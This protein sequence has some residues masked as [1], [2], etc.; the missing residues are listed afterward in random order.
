MKRGWAHSVGRR[1]AFTLMEAIAAIVVLGVIV[2]PSVSMLRT[3]AVARSGSIDT[4]RATWLANGVLEQVIADVSSPTSSLGMSALA[5]SSTYVDTAT[6][7]L[8]ARMAA[9]TA[10]YPSTF[11]WTLTIGSLVSASGSSTGSA[12]ADV[13]RYVQVNVTWPT[14]HGSKT[15]NV[16]ALVTD[17]RP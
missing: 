8:R 15:L 17:L 14:P 7:G 4:I 5:N 3:A 13:Y 10:G 1:R 12:A 9:V 2:P 16:G 11:S 6:T